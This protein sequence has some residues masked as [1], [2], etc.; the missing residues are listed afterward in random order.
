MLDFFTDFRFEFIYS[1]WLFVRTVIDSFRYQGLAF[2]LFFT[3]IATM[4]D[5]VCYFLVPT[6]LVYLLGSSFVWI[7][8]VWQ[9]DRGFYAPTIVLCFIFVYVEVAVRLRDPKHIP[10][11]IDICRPFATH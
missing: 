2:A 9:S 11:G 7:Q 4:S 5:V 1:C 10:L 3:L 6:T 8:L